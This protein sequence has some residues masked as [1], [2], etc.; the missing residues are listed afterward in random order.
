[1]EEVGWVGLGWVFSRYD[2]L[3]SPWQGRFYAMINNSET[4]S[5]V[6][7]YSK[8]PQ[9]RKEAMPVSLLALDRY[10]VKAVYQLWGE[11]F[12]GECPHC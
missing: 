3:P 8:S 6:K 2:T 9:L 7:H 1:M 10:H 5:T 4:Y 12:G 11:E